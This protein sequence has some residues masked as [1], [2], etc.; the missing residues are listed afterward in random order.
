MWNWI[1]SWINPRSKHKVDYK[2]YPKEDNYIVY[3][4]LRKK[5][6]FAFRLTYLKVNQ[7]NFIES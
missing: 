1:D 7:T 5:I 3:T 6:N 2:I 4:F